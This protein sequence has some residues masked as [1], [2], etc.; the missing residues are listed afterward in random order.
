MELNFQNHIRQVVMEE[1]KVDSRGRKFFLHCCKDCGKE[2][3]IRSDYV[4]KHKMMCRSCFKKSNWRDDEFREKCSVSHV[5]H[6]CPT[7]LPHG[8]A[9][10]NMIYGSYKR[11]AKVRGIEFNLSKEDFKVITSQNCYY[12][13]VPANQIFAPNNKARI[14]GNY[15]YNGVDR[16][17]PNS[18]YYKENVVP[19][20]K[21]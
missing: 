10:F 12:C 5:G 7:K 16:K 14:N 8:I 15:I 2:L 13:G 4:S 6:P 1:C 20:C 3:Y 19:C 21:I 9:S 11:G 18:G 17:N